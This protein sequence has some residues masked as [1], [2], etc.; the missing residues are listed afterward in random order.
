MYPWLQMQRA[1][2]LRQFEFGAL[3]SKLDLHEPGAIEGVIGNGAG[4]RKRHL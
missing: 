3:Q 2:P 1:W 4:E